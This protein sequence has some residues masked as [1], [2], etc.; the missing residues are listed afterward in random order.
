MVV[1]QF[2]RGGYS[3]FAPSESAAYA[4]YLGATLS[5]L[6]LERV[7]ANT[8]IVSPLKKDHTASL[9][10][11]AVMMIFGFGLMGLASLKRRFK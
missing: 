5:D 9:P 10:E 8:N 7:N 4:D 3:G 1:P 11:P 6:R 2:N